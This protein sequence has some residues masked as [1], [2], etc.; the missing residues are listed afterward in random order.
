MDRRH[1][2]AAFKSIAHRIDRIMNNIPAIRDNGKLTSIQVWILN[3]LFRNEGKDMFQRDVEREFHI[4]RSTA[5]EIL[6]AMER[7]DLIRRER[8]D[9]DARLKKIVLTGYAAEIRKQLQTQMRR[10]EA[11]LTDGFTDDEIRQFFA[12][13]D[14]FKANL[15]KCE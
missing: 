9:Y 14:R 11:A 7:N 5:T 4:R 6:T 8:T 3:F 1:I 2:G 12:F 15:E 10:L 13:A